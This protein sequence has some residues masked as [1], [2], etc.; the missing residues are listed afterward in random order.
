MDIGLSNPDVL[1]L[2]LQKY[3]R[4]L[5]NDD[6]I[7]VQRSDSIEDFDIENR[8]AKM[9]FFEIWHLPRIRSQRKIIEDWVKNSPGWI[10]NSMWRFG[11]NEEKGYQLEL[12]KI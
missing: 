7:I 4:D 11:P 1:A 8:G 6:N 2:S 10:F 12:E 9:F 3:L 5:N